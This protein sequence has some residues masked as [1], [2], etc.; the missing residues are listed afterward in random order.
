M[1]TINAFFFICYSYTFVLIIREAHEALRDFLDGSIPEK[2]IA[3]KK[4]KVS[5]RE[6]EREREREQKPCQVFQNDI[7]HF[8]NSSFVPKLVGIGS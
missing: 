3:V 2:E 1:T 4:I 7:C 5:V 6:R 8:E